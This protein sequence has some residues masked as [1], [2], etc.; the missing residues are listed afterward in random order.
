MVGPTT[1]V[2]SRR[3]GN[4]DSCRKSRPAPWGGESGPLA[5][6][7]RPGASIQTNA[8]QHLDDAVASAHAIAFAFAGLRG[9]SRKFATTI[10]C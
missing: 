8:V 6:K 7:E 5:G 10:N 3:D 1:V 2:D 4:L 9:R